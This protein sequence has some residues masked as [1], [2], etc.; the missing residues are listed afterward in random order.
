MTIHWD[1]EINLTC[2]HC[3]QKVKKSLAWIKENPVFACPLGC[4][5]TFEAVEF[6]ASLEEAHQKFAEATAKAFEDV[7]I[8]I[9]VKL[10]HEGL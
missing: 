1:S 3:G 2:P 5:F 7:A 9:N 6:L 4:G 10:T 8:D